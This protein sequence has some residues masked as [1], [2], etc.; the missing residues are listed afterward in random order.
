MY[1]NNCHGCTGKLEQLTWVNWKIG[2]TA[3]DLLELPWMYWKIGTTNMG[4]LHVLEQL[5]VLEHLPQ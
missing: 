5:T 2:T 3:M 4:L 1:W